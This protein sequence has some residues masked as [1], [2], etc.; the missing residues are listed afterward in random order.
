MKEI[1][2]GIHID[3]P[4]YIAQKTISV[5]KRANRYKNSFLHPHITLVY[6]RFKK[7]NFNQLIENLNKQDFV[8]GQVKLGIVKKTKIKNKDKYFIYLSLRNIVFI[9]NLH[10]QTLLVANKLR[11]ELLRAKDVKR[12]K[13]GQLT[14]QEIIYLKK[15]GNS[16]V[17]KNYN[18]HITLGELNTN[19]ISQFNKMK[20]ELA[21]LTGRNVKIN[22][23]K[24]GLFE[25]DYQKEQFKLLEEKEIILT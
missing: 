19:Q 10:K 7:E 18:S 2:I 22:Q 15:Y 1:Q 5:R 13:T 23:Y 11:R 6:M 14:K 24:V 8:Q 20:R 12:L 9:N 4:K 16:R 25:F 21:V 17:L 3:L